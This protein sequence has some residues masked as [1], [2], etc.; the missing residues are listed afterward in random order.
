MLDSCRRAMSLFT[1]VLCIVVASALPTDHSRDA[2]NRDFDSTTFMEKFGYLDNLAGRGQHD[3]QTTSMGI[4]EFQ[5]FNGLQETGRLDPATVQK[6]Q[7]PRCG[8]P[9]LV[10]PSERAAQLRSDPET[11]L[12]F[13]APGYKWRK[14]NIDYKIVGYTRQLGGSDQRRALRQAFSK[15]SGVTPLTF[16]EV[17]SGT[18][19]IEINFVRGQH[20]DGPGNTFDGRGGTLAHAFFP[21]TQP[22]SGDTHFDEDEQWTMRGETGSN[23]EI[24]AAHEFGHALGLGHSNVPTALMAPYYQ[25]YDPN[26]Q[27]HVDDKRGIQTLYGSGGGR[28]GGRRTRPTRPPV[29]AR[30]RPRPRA[31]PAPRGRHCDVKFDDIIVAHDGKTYAFRGSKI[32]RLTNRGVSRGFPRPRNRVFRGAPSSPGAVVYDRRLR[33]TFFFKGGRYWRFT[34][35]RK[36]QGFP[37]R[38]PSAF[39]NPKAALQWRDGRIYL[40]KSSTYTAWTETLTRASSGYPRAT[41]QFWRGLRPDIEAA[42]QYTDGETYFFKGNVYW[43]FDS[44]YGRVEAGYPKATSQAWLGCTPRI[45]K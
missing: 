43:K 16:R 34:A 30:P 21:G 2:A 4:R 18:A 37:K 40:F 35:Y 8:L 41:T 9:D 32:Y 25:G 10:R 7:S 23:L 1:L 39:R 22:I 38:L 12:A 27:L 45:P 19:D 20:G 3:P 6:M 42:F 11:P 29:T 14:N 33:K 36:D 26:Y 15:W 24:V 44:Y 5:R 13:Y 31:T 17:T 28:S